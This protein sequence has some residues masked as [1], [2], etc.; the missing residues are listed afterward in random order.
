MARSKFVEEHAGTEL[1]TFIRE[2]QQYFVSNGKDFLLLSSTQLDAL[3]EFMPL[4]VY[5]CACKRHREREMLR[6]MNDNPT[7]SEKKIPSA[8]LACSL[9]VGSREQGSE[10]TALPVELF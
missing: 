3:C 1:E 2:W 9:N 7:P 5:T 10:N 8:Q 4:R 6:H